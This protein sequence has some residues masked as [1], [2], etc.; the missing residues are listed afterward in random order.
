MK[1]FFLLLIPFVLL[2]LSGCTPKYDYTVHKPKVKY[3]KPSRDALARTLKE[4]LGTEYVWAEEGPKAFDCSGLTYYSYGRM[5]MPIPRVAREQAKVGE[6]VA[7][8]DLAYGDLIFFDTTKRRAG[9]ITH[10]GI[11]VGDGKF[12]H[13]SSSKE[14]VIISDLNSSYY[15]PRIVTCRRYLPS[16]PHAT[17]T[18]L[19]PS[20]ST[21]PSAPY[22][23]AKADTGTI[24]PLGIE[25]RT[26]HAATVSRHTALAQGKHYIQVGSFSNTPDQGLF[27][28]IQ[29]N[30]YRYK[31]L[32][33]SNL[34]KVL[35]GPYHSKAE[36]L[37]YLDDIRATI[38]PDAFTT[39]I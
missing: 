37:R 18:P 6:K 20:P 32:Q 27:R 36:A 14:G 23:I 22:R 1:S 34:K 9:K 39:K 33:A 31:I 5:N 17:P 4:K 26:I 28:Q 16:D 25:E 30:G 38:L 13:A 3:K 35:I 12:Q 19:K 10:V 2:S 15:R 29:S 21:T 11:Y 8:N 24:T 7:L